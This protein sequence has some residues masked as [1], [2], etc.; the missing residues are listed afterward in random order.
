MN[1]TTVLT[2][3]RDALAGRP[4]APALQVIRRT[5]DDPVFMFAWKEFL[6]T[7]NNPDEN[8]ALLHEILRLAGDG[9]VRRGNQLTNV[10]YGIGV[11]GSM[12]ASSLIGAATAATG[13][14]FLIPLVVGGMVTAYCMTGTG[15]L[16]QEEIL[17]KDI[18][19]R[20]SKLLEET[21][22]E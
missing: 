8:V 11:G 7:S 5:L 12:M 20:A 10:K 22:E 2:E 13:G 6:R 17:Y 15:P 4:D 21:D 9:G 1:F 14:F 3:I 16:S 18:E 19:A